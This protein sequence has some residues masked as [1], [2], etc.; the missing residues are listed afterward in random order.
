MMAEWLWKVPGHH[1]WE[2]IEVEGYEAAFDTLRCRRCNLRLRS[3]YLLTDQAPLDVCLDRWVLG[4]FIGRDLE[5]GWNCFKF[6][7]YWREHRELSGTSSRWA[8]WIEFRLY[9]WRTIHWMINHPPWRRRIK[10]WR[11]ELTWRLRDDYS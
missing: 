8:R 3:K 11:P 6:A 9:H 5:R 4:T 1:S 2:H 7:V 10:I